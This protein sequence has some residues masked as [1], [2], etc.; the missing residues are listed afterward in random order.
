[1][2]PP[3]RVRADVHTPSQLPAPWWPCSFGWPP[4]HAAGPERAPGPSVFHLGHLDSVQARLV[5]F[6]PGSDDVRSG[7]LLQGEGQK[8]HAHTKD[9]PMGL[10]N[11]PWENKEAFS[12]LS[13]PGT[14]QP[15][16]PEAAERAPGTPQP[17]D[18]QLALLQLLLP[19]T[20]FRRQRPLLT[21]EMLTQEV[22]GRG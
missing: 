20:R 1:M 15:P 18:S 19:R 12:S 10:T 13:S 2:S 3:S 21:P 8:E 22:G 5:C 9:G 17:P 7:L 4:G 6:P 11:S 16:P 14:A